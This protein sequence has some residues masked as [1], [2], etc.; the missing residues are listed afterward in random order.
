MSDYLSVM[1]LLSPS[2]LAIV[3]PV[4]IQHFFSSLGTQIDGCLGITRVKSKFPVRIGRSRP[5]TVGRS[6][7]SIG[8]QN[9]TARPRSI[10]SCD[11]DQGSGGTHCREE[12]SR[13]EWPNGCC[14]SHW[15]REPWNPG[16]RRRGDWQ[17]LLA[18]S[19]WKVTDVNLRRAWVTPASR[20]NR[21][22]SP[23]V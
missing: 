4:V 16:D 7:G 21:T 14:L 12:S 19:G 6:V 20:C 13:Y 3:Y 8:V 2:L 1:R 11:A 22:I 9:K 5:A 10:N 17:R 15:Q 18:A 23:L